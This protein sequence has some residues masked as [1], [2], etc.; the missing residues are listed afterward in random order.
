MNPERVQPPQPPPSKL[1]EFPGKSRIAQSRET[2]RNTTPAWKQE[3]NE[4]LRAVR[5]KR[6]IAGPSTAPLKGADS[7][8]AENN[9]ATTSAMRDVRTDAPPTP[10]RAGSYRPRPMDRRLVASS[11]VKTPMRSGAAST[12]VKS[13]VEP[14]APRA[15][16]AD[17]SISPALHSGLEP[18]R[19]YAPAPAL[20]LTMDKEATAKALEPEAK[21]EALPAQRSSESGTGSAVC[22]QPVEPVVTGSQQVTPPPTPKTV[23]LSST[24]YEDLEEH[25]ASVPDEIE[26]RD[27][28][29]EEVRRVDRALHEQFAHEEGVSLG[30]HLVLNFVDAITIALATLPF[31]AVAQI[32]NGGIGSSGSRFALGLVTLLVAA[33]YLAL[34]QCLC[35]K[36][37]GMMLTN[38]HVADSLTHAPMTPL[39][40]LLRT[41]G[42]FVAIA[43]ATIGILW[44][45]TNRRHR[46]WQDILSGTVVVQDE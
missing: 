5:E 33:F 37:F 20:P 40:G 30:A 21:V 15:R 31:V 43:P 7:E 44:A 29:A 1:I 14:A 39:R 4:R 2:G 22:R 35:G 23:I 45:V 32:V 16:R 46:G 42:Y 41:L 28:L 6:G 19:S 11:S 8:P 27:Y 38:T 12:A 13:R 24:R 18:A 17:E 36:T 10:K 25:A 26:P 34:T 9:P 3:L